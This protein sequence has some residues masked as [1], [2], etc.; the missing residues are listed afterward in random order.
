[1]FICQKVKKSDMLQWMQMEQNCKE[2]RRKYLNINAQ[3]E[4][5]ELKGGVLK[6]IKT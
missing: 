1:M 4:L 5:V 3:K 2:H 6:T